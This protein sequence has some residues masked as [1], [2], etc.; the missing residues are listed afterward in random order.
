MVGRLVEKEAVRI[1][2][3][4][5]Q[6]DNPSLHAVRHGLHLS[7]LEIAAYSKHSQLASPLWRLHLRHSLRG[8]D[9]IRVESL[10]ESQRSLF[11]V[12]DFLAVLVVVANSQLATSLDLTDG[13]LY[14]LEHELEEGGLPCAVRPDEGDAGVQIDT[15]FQILVEVVFFLPRVGERA[16]GK[17]QHWW[18]DLLRVW[19]GERVDWV[20]LGLLCETG[21]YHLVDDLLLRRRL[22]QHV[23]VCTA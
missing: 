13:G 14:L 19:K 15:Q 5:K 1:H 6:H 7:C 21:L 8:H 2:Q 4:Y 18:R 23:L 22:D 10:Q 11:K 17:R 16:V 12:Q 20:N 3:R 9:T